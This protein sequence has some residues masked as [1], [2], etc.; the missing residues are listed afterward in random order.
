VSPLVQGNQVVISAGARVDG[1]LV[2][3]HNRAHPQGSCY[4]LFIEEISDNGKAFSVH[5]LLHPSSV[6]EDTYADCSDTIRLQAT[7]NG[8]GKATIGSPDSFAAAARQASSPLGAS[9]RPGTPE[10]A[11]GAQIPFAAGPYYALIIG[12]DNYSNLPK[13]KT[14]VNDAN[15]I[16]QLLRRH[17]GFQTKVLLDASRDQILTALIE[18]RQLLPE[19]SNLLIYYAGHGHHDRDTDE[20]YWL[21]V[22]ARA[23]NNAN[24]ISADDITR[25]IRAISSSHVLVI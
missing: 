14:A 3:L 10:T 8:E 25:D 5:A 13:L 19:H 6:L 21:P 15:E 22:D 7:G 23:N 18:Y 20:S 16:A 17:F 11:A 4:D 1:K 9:A 24:W 12:N 2:L